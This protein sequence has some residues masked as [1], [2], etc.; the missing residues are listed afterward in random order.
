MLTTD[1]ELNFRDHINSKV[2]SSKG[3]AG[4]IRSFKALDTKILKKLFIGLVRPHLEY[5]QSV[6][7]PYYSKDIEQIENVQR[8]ASKKILGLKDL[9]YKDRLKELSMPTLVYRRLRGDMIECYKITSNIYDCRVSQFLTYHE[10]VTEQSGRTRGHNKRLYV[11]TAERVVRIKDFTF[12]NHR[13][14]PD[15]SVLF[16]LS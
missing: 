14:V 4:I 10:Y 15:K 6:W 5:A 9:D 2:Q 7:S 8:R 3:I 13:H 11:K 1:K 12:L 16:V